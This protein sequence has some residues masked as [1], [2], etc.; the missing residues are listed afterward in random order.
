M[1]IFQCVIRISL[2]SNSNH[3]LLSFSCAPQCNSM[4]LLCNTLSCCKWLQLDFSFTLLF[5][6]L[7]KSDL[8]KCSRNFDLQEIIWN[9]VLFEKSLQWS[10]EFMGVL[11]CSRHPL[12]IP[13][14]CICICPMKQVVP[15]YLIPGIHSRSFSKCSCEESFLLCMWERC[16]IFNWRSC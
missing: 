5:S 8:I 3:C 1:N 4:W 10:S 16:N 2:V 7:N 13:S 11:T 12:L 14:L 9:S 15:G 6:R